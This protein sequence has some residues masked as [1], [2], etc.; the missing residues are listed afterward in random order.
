MKEYYLTLNKDTFIWV[1]NTSGIVY[2]STNFRCFTFKRTPAIDDIYNTLTKIENLYCA[3]ITEMVLNDSDVTIF[4]DNIKIIEAGSLIEK[5]ENESTK[6]ISYVPILKIQ[7]DISRLRHLHESG[8]QTNDIIK[9]LTEITLHVNG[10]LNIDPTIHRQCIAPSDYSESLSVEE[11]KNFMDKCGNYHLLS[12]NVVGDFTKYMNVDQL[13]DYLNSFGI[14]HYNV[15]TTL[16]SWLD[17]KKC[18]NRKLNNTN[19]SV[20][21]FVDNDD[22]LPLVQNE[23]GIKFC[24]PVSDENSYLQIITTIDNYHI[25]DFEIIPIA[26]EDNQ[27]FESYVYTTIEDLHSH[28]FSKREIFA[29]QAI[30]NNFFGKFTVMPNGSIYANLNHPS[31]G[32]IRDSIYNLIYN[33]LN[34]GQSWRMIRDQEPC[35]NC[36]YQWLCPSPSN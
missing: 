14:P 7:E 13:F 8:T 25:T 1:K 12:L 28:S 10:D 29:N 31:V 2:N 27:F 36:I 6:P 16:S 26:G 33:E 20:V 9:N 3:T 19:S 11:I 32:T 22:L 18:I 17:S 21:V 4:I 5:N 34:S 30:N 15:I 23:N 35:C 24:F